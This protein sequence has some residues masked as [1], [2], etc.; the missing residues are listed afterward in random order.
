MERKGTLSCD[1]LKLTAMLTML[2]DHIGAGILENMFYRDDISTQAMELLY[3]TD[4][5]FRL[6]GRIAFPVFCYLLLQGFL[7]TGNRA[8]YAGNLLLFAL[9]SELPFDYLFYGGITLLHQ[10]VFWTLLIGLLTLWGVETMENAHLPASIQI[11]SMCAV[12]GAGLLMAALLNTDYTWMGVAMILTFYFSRDY[13]ILQCAVTFIIFFLA[14]TAH[15]QSAF[16]S[17]RES[18]WYTL[19]SEWTLLIAFAMIYRCNG[20]RHIKKGK[21]LFYAF[22]PVHILILWL[23]LKLI[24][25]L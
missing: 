8:K 23:I 21:Y 1:T 20:I 9:L 18:F 2:I 25:S 13:R 14:L 3:M 11:V 7:H 6:I 12:S 24:G 15:Y 4:S 5:I 16:S 19:D 22:Y 17:W 10:N